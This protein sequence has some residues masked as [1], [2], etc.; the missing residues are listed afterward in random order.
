MD[1]NTKAGLAAAVEEAR[2]G[3]A[4]GGIPI[5][6]SLMID[7]AVIA[8]GHNQRVQRGSQILHGEMAAIENCGRRRD[9]GKM[10]LFTTLSPCMMCAGTIVQFG[11]PRVVIAENQNFG[12]NEEFLRSRGIEVTVLNDPACIEMMRDFISAHPELWDED[13]GE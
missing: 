1:E 5:G 2:K 3:L 10:T 8:A 13:I 7:G 4:E 9:Y 12:G 6:S 11:I